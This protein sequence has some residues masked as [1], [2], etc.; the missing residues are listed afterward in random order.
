[1]RSD[2]TCPGGP[3]SIVSSTT[4]LLGMVRKVRAFCLY[5]GCPAA[6]HGTHPRS[7]SRICHFLA[8]FEIVMCQGGV[9]K[10]GEPKA[11]RIFE[12]LRLREATPTCIT[13][14]S[15]PVSFLRDGTFQTTRKRRA[16]F[17]RIV[18]LLVVALLFASSSPATA[19]D[20]YIFRHEYP[21]KNCIRVVEYVYTVDIYTKIWEMH[22]DECQYYEEVTVTMTLTT[23]A[24]FGINEP[25]GDVTTVTVCPA[26]HVPEVC[27]AQV[28][29]NHPEIEWRT[30][31]FTLD[32]RGSDGRLTSRG[33]GPSTCQSFKYV[34]RCREDWVVRT[35]D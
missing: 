16:P 33:G 7:G 5:T 10:M 34:A 13:L 22:R 19:E 20:I 11:R 15:R 32:A 27:I 24:R 26:G 29:M 23:D 1:M 2:K 35:P 21:V 14:L 31:Y 6:V 8:E 30:Y 17:T 18:L 12:V 28:S 9:A 25:I 3:T 4:T